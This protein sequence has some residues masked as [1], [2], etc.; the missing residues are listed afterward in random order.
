MNNPTLHLRINNNVIDCVNELKILGLLI[1]N[2]L[3]WKQHNYQH[4]K[5]KVK[6][7][8]WLV[9]ENMTLFGLII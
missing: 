7:N 9:M 2:N 1:D 5:S 8:Y 4:S 6:W 3:T